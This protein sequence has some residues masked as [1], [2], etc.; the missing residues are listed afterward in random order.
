MPRHR[1]LI[2]S[3][4][5]PPVM[6]GGLGRH[7]HAL[8]DALVEVGQDVVVLSQAPSQAAANSRVSP[9]APQVV[10]AF[11]P[12]EF[13]DVYADTA[14]FVDGLQARL[15]EAAGPL[16]STWRPD[17]VHG[18]D[19]VVA[20]AATRLAERAACPLVMTVH[21][22]ESGLYHGNVHSPFSRWRHGVE[23]EMVRRAAASIVCSGAMRDEVV[24]RLGADPG[25]VVV[26]PNGVHPAQWDAGRADQRAVRNRLGIGE[27]PLLV[28][29]GRLE[30]EKGAQDAIAALA[31]LTERHP[32]AHLALVGD[33]ARA[34]DLTEQAA[35]A[36]LA[37][38]VHLLGRLDDS[39]VAA[40]LSAADV[41]LVP[42]RYEPFGLVALEAM[43]AGTPLVA[44]DVGGL[45]DIVEDGVSG[46]LV[47]P[48][49]PDAL[50]DAVAALLADPARRA[51]LAQAGAQRVRSRF[52][53][54]AVAESTAR[55]YDDV[56]G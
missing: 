22:T 55:V 50:A 18:H 24:D 44:A 37:D 28:L 4:E 53:W 42:S 39:S 36:G 17:V 34:D 26:V 14:A 8:A 2:V 49:E 11:L 43:A 23:R 19:W 5:Y 20:E 15:V 45:P 30:H 13:P 32:D 27:E 31:A 9:T 35:R 7:V 10:R 16:L 40:V 56:L 41:A 33:G 12:D 38:R 6:Y 3:W 29:V 47:P 21:A 54:S 51:A 25:S 48:A 46:V 1:V 52:A